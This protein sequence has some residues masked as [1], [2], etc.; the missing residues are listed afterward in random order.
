[1]ASLARK[2]FCWRAV[3]L[4]HPQVCSLRDVAHAVSDFGA[5]SLAGASTNGGAR[6]ACGSCG[7]RLDEPATHYVHCRGGAGAGGGNYYSS[8]HDAMVA[9]VAD[10]LRTVYGGRGRVVVED[11]V[12]AMHYSPHHRP[13]ITVMDAFGVGV[14]LLI[15]VTVFR[16]TA[17][18]NVRGGGGGASGSA[19][20]AVRAGGGPLS[21]R[22]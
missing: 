3:P 1:M 7:T 15:E 13:D 18:S 6:R 16:S 11:H 21:G 10:M 19:L 2:P 14:H 20:R 22:L 12:G 5:L 8:L 4:G 17:V 9:V